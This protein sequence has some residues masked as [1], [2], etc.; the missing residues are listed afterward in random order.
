MKYCPFCYKKSVSWIKSIIQSEEKIS[1]YFNYWSCNHCK[2]KFI[3]IIDDEGNI[4]DVKIT[5]EKVTVQ[6]T[7]DDFK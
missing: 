4:L 3:E 5:D 7:F 6:T 2:K 1:M